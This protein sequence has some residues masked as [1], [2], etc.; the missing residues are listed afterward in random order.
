M[1]ALAGPLLAAF[2]ALFPAFPG[3]PASEP[4]AGPAK[5]LLL[6]SHYQG[7][8]WTDSITA[9]IMA[10]LSGS[11]RPADLSVAYLD[12]R[13]NLDEAYEVAFKDYLEARFAPIGRFDLVIAA[14]NEALLRELHH[15]VKNNLQIVSSILSLGESG[16]EGAA[17]AAALAAA[18]RRVEAMAFV[19][20]ELYES[21]DHSRVDFA[22]LIDRVIVSLRAS[23]CPA[24]VEVSHP[25]AGS[26][27]L[28]IDKAFPCGL[29]VEELVSN[30][31]SHAFAGRRSGRVTVSA[32]DEGG[33]LRLAVEDDGIGHP[34]G[35]DAARADSIGY[36]IVNSLAEQ[37]GATFTLRSGPG[38]S[39]ATLVLPS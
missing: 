31:L 8:A 39:A 7:Y 2:V 23:R 18:K 5:V 36:L 26:L 28:S 12:S 19:H 17:T 34:G 9:G 30:A 14:D 33:L 29:I 21:E 13:R 38:G 15:R 37:L 24:G 1:S 4:P 10:T 6:H 3:F 27:Y 25:D 20:E 16:R 22:A 11:A 32:S 35:F